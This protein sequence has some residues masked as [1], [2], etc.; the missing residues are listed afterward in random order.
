[1]NIEI[2][3]TT[4]SFGD[5]YS[6][7]INS[8]LLY[9]AC[10]ETRHFFDNALVLSRLD[11]G[12]HPRL[13]LSRNLSFFTASYDLLHW[14]ETMH[15][16]EE[17]YAQFKTRSLWKS[18]YQCLHQQDVY[19]IYTHPNQLRSV[20]KNE[21]MI[22]C[23]ERAALAPT[24]TDCYKI[25]ADDDCEVELLIS[26]C[27]ILDNFSSSNKQ[28]LVQLELGLQAEA[29]PFDPAWKPKYAPLDHLWTSS[30]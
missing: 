11:H 6:I 4:E 10:L 12:K 8:F 20:Y 29:R 2:T 9:S 27:L 17:H 3:R 22:A 28:G 30:L 18:H 13:L 1:M 21:Q 19:D 24:D 7:S 5:A 16:W 14:N 15:A 23:W 25:T 26:F